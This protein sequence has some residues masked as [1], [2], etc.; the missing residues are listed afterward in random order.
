M[1]KKKDEILAW[2]TGKIQ[3]ISS[4]RY[5][6]YPECWKIGSI[7]KERSSHNFTINMCHKFGFPLC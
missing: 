3:E 5:R 7:R 1:V 2:K 4:L 6:G